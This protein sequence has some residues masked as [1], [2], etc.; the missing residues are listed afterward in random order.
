MSRTKHFKTG[1][2]PRQQVAK[3][4]YWSV[5]NSTLSKHTDFQLKKLNDLNEVSNKARV[6][7]SS[8]SSASR[9]IKKVN[10][11]Q[12]AYMKATDKGIGKNPSIAH[13]VNSWLNEPVFKS[14]KG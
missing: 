11:A 13:R 8:N 10:K 2:T 1:M 7:L 3:R 4:G 12:E 9:S 14:K 6:K 5:S